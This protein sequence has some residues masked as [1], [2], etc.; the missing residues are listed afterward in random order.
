MLFGL[1]VEGEHDAADALPGKQ[2][3]RLLDTMSV[4]DAGLL[5]R[6]F[7]SGLFGLMGTD[8]AF[9]FGLKVILLGIEQ[10]VEEQAE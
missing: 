1:L 9:E 2:M 5:R 3:I 4:T 6:I 10:V 8:K 7:T